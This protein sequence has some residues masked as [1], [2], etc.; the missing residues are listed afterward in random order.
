MLFQY[1]STNFK[2]SIIKLRKIKCVKL[3]IFFSKSVYLDPINNFRIRNIANAYQN[4][5]MMGNPWG[6]FGYP[7][8][9]LVPGNPSQY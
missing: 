5:R 8:S 9:S 4:R 6:I 2:T 3:E 1:L 7:F